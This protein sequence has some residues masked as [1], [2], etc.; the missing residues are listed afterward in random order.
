M[1]HARTIR[2][3][4][5]GRKGREIGKENSSSAAVDFNYYDFDA[6]MMSYDYNLFILVARAH[7]STVVS[8][9]AKLPDPMGTDGTGT[10]GPRG[11]K[12][13]NGQEGQEGQ[14]GQMSKGVSRDTAEQGRDGK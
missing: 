7:A 8:M 14:E 9:P 6:T 3:S 5:G 11:S 10:W 4:F 2:T 1:T 13:Q 12:G